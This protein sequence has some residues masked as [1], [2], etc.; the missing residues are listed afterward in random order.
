[1]VRHCGLGKENCILNLKKKKK[2]NKKVF[3]GIVHSIKSYFK[4]SLDNHGFH[5]QLWTGTSTVHK[6]V[7]Y[8]GID[9]RLL[10][11]LGL[12]CLTMPGW[13]SFGM[14]VKQVS[15]FLSPLPQPSPQVWTTE[16]AAVPGPWSDPS[17]CLPHPGL[18]PWLLS[19]PSRPTAPLPGLAP[20]GESGSAVGREEKGW[21]GLQGALQGPGFVSSQLRGFLKL[22]T[23]FEMEIIQDLYNHSATKTCRV[24]GI[25]ENSLSL[26]STLGDTSIKL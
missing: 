20:M 16:E 24:L 3:S 22:N 5:L 13:T 23:P 7:D 19:P 17:P 6:S 26:G 2:T 18:Y 14:D 4:K 25:F 15:L 12:R 21:R 1:M 9:S 8:F 10:R 11:P